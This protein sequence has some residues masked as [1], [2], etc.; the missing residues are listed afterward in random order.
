MRPTAILRIAARALLLLAAATPLSTALSPSLPQAHAQSRKPAWLGVVMND[1]AVPGSVQVQR[2]M[3]G[4]PAEQAGLRHGDRIVRVA[5]QPVHRA[6][7]VGHNISIKVP[8]SVVPLQ[9][10]RDGRV[11][12][13][14]VRLGELPSS[15][16]LLR[17]QHVGVA[18][19]ELVGL[20]SVDSQS[21]PPSLAALKGRVV[22]LDFWA[23]W[24]EACRATT[25]RLN[26]L[27][28]RYSKKGLT[29]LGLGSDEV[30]AIRQSVPQFGIRYATAADP[31]AATA[32]LYGV[33]ELPSVLLI[34]SQGV[35]REVSTGVD[36]QGMR[37]IEQMV[38]QMLGEAPSQQ[39][40]PQR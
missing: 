14:A 22:I 30:P 28:S 5:Q 17:M 37:R 23:P 21:P 15:A 31:N 32:Q 12:D 40:N 1:T 11:I 16:Q 27:Q 20:Q 26:A 3:R 19:P 4:S 29:V 35:V 33:R 25:K 10:E 9:L 6:A 13:V 8:G 36:P 39:S 24:C 38:E 34:D 18:A 7:D 2:I